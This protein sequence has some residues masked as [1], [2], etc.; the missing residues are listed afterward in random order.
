MFYSLLQKSLDLGF[1]YIKYGK[2]AAEGTG[3]AFI[4]FTQAIVELP[5][6]PFWAVIFF[7]MLLSLGV[8]SQIGIL[9]GML[10]TI[11]DIELLKRI[12]KQY[13][14]ASVCLICF[15]VGLIFC[16]GAGEYWLTLFDSFAGT[17]G[18]V[19]VALLETLA[20]MYVYGHEK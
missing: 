13:I 2:C 17:I 10:C 11:F 4:V 6:S 20:V 14:T 18:L 5:G 16:T 9:E 8:G 12:R 7:L 15:L 19:L 3:L 1:H